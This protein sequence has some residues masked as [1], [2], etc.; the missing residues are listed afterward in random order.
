MKRANKVKQKVFFVI[1]KGLLFPK[2]NS[3]LRVR[4]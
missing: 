1:F 4:L 3:D 2:T